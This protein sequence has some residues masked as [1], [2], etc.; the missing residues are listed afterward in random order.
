MFVLC[1]HCQFLVALDPASGQP[2]THCPRCHN[3][4][5]GPAATQPTHAPIAEASAATPPPP[6]TAD[7]GTPPP[8][9]GAVT[10]APNATIVGAATSTE[11]AI[12]DVAEDAVAG[13]TQP[14]T[15]TESDPGLDDAAA[16][17]EAVVFAEQPSSDA[18]PGAVETS[19]EP[20]PSVATPRSASGL[21][22][23]TDPRA[24]AS[25]PQPARRKPGS[26][27]SFARASQ[28]ARVPDRRRHWLR[29]AAI[30]ALSLL[31]GLQLLL[32]DRARLAG[33][34]RWR[35]TL[36]LLCGVLRCSLPPWREPAAFALLQRDVRPHPTVPGALRVTATFRND[37]R[38]PQPWPSLLLTLS[39]LDGRSAGARA[40][41]AREYLGAAPTRSGLAS[42][43]SATIAMDV[44]EPAPRIVAFTFDFR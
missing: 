11:R 13:A 9:S 4:L 27:P 6:E 17:V 5:P 8:A 31:L 7:A 18:D 2:P 3:G 14:G 24:D 39:D 40:F 10:A 28:P 35:P 21:A 16:P 44:V 33:D 23:G 22:A 26:A 34:A 12:G 42:G 29:L 36:T 19:G 41:V 20:A 38:W 37:A 43:Q 25:G 32:A 30:A 1:P 15:P